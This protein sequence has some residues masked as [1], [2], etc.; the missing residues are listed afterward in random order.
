MQW[1]QNADCMQYIFAQI[2]HVLAGKTLF[3]LSLKE[4]SLIMFFLMLDL[5]AEFSLYL[6]DN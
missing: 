3:V 5:K 1:Q 2:Q 4:K 6:S